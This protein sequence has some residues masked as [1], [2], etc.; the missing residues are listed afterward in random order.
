MAFTK[1]VNMKGSI[2]V[3]YS[4]WKKIASNKA[5]TEMKNIIQAIP[6]FFF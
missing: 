2:S 6:V 5:A 4:K 3:R 1:E